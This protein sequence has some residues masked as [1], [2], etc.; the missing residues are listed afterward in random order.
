MQVMGVRIDEFDLGADNLV[1]F[2][3]GLTPKFIMVHFTGILQ[4]DNFNPAAMLPPPNRY[5]TMEQVPGF[6]GSYL[7][8]DGDYQITMNQSPGNSGMILRDLTAPVNVLRT[9]ALGVCA[10]QF[11]NNVVDPGGVPFYNGIG[12]I[13]YVP[14]SGAASLRTFVRAMGFD[15]DGD[16][17][18][19]WW[20][21][22]IDRIVIRVNRGEDKT[23]VRAEIDY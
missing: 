18:V 19:D 5:F 8:N 22:A 17:W 21:K 11:P 3:A 12:Q 20:F 16:I 6:P 4:G 15:P 1:C 2:A 7:F 9:D 14:E 13:T 23:T 10:T